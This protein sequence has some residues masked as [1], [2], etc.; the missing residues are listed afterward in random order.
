[1]SDSDNRV[2]DARPDDDQ[3]DVT[4]RPRTLTE[5]VGQ[6]QVRENLGILLE[7]ARRRGAEASRSS[8]F[9]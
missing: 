4:L 1:M 8:T 9:C 2:L 5:Y 3:Y 7:A 6:A